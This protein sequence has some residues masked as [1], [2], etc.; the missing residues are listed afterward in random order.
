MS[1]NPGAVL[2]MAGKSS[3]VRDVNSLRRNLGGEVTRQRHSAV[4]EGTSGS[5]APVTPEQQGI[6]GQSEKP[7]ATGNEQA[8][9]RVKQN[10]L[11]PADGTRP[12]IEGMQQAILKAGGTQIVERLEAMDAETAAAK[13]TQPEEIGRLIESSYVPL[14]LTALEE[15]SDEEFASEYPNERQATAAQRTE[16][17]KVIKS[18]SLECPRCRLKAMSDWEWEKHVNG[19]ADK[20]FVES[21]SRD[22]RG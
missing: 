22:L 4:G 3:V 1:R 14:L 20:K 11:A 2:K 8:V 17:A 18:H 9:A 19:I 10:K 6:R 7:L 15:L 13:C 21:K 12:D 16:L 5:R